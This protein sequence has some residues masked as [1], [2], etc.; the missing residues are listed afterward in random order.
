MQTRVLGKHNL[1]IKEQADQY[2]I[3]EKD[4]G[5]QS[6]NIPSDTNK[7]QNNQVNTLRSK[8]VLIRE[9]GHEKKIAKLFRVELNK[10]VKK[11]VKREYRHFVNLK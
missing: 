5:E 11:I 1:K 6:I 9:I 10:I 8:K 7:K 4:S 2:S 3:G